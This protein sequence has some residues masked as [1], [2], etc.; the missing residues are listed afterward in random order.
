M[1]VDP[2]LLQPFAG[3]PA[4]Q[5]RA[6]DGA[7]AVVLL[8]GGQLVSWIPA[9]GVERIFLSERARYGEG[10]SVRGGMPVIF[11]QF[12]ERGPLPRHGFVRNR[13]W[14]VVRAETGADDAL[15]VLQR[16]DDESTRAI[17]PHP[18]AL[19]LTV[20][21]RG[22]RL[23]VELS[24]GNAGAGPFTF[25]AALHTY[26]RVAEVEGGRLS[27]LRGRSYEDFTAGRLRSDEEPTLRVEGEVDRIYFD[28]PSPLELAD[29]SRRLLIESVNFPDTVVWNP[30]EVKGAALADLAP[31]D[32][33]RFL[34]VE[35]ALI[36][37]PVA[38]EAGGQWWGRQTL[39]A[40]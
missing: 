13:P 15:A 28:A 19:E 11:P 38:L 1:D 26:L 40:G 3:Q 23:D 27:G 31:A 22:D 2:K 29:G 32:F 20:C 5:L 17:W 8:H 6:P 35:A 18:F 12:N 16:L 10:A 21:I 39:I 9:G 4:V 14:Q 25:M 24:V 37:T 30:W 34:C 7:S 33:R 36:G